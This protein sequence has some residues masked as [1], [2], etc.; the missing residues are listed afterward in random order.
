M[1]ENVS[2]GLVDELIS[3]PCPDGDANVAWTKICKNYENSTGATK[4]KM[5]GQFNDPTL[6]KL[7]KDPDSWISE[8]ELLRTRL[9]KIGTDIGDIYM[10]MHVLNNAPS[11]YDNVFENLED[12]LDVTTDPLTLETL[13][14]K[15]SEKN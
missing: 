8:L 2:F 4:V 3:L 12:K 14:E 5:I 10:M 6:N 11:A 1:T 13:R 15:L 9:K 7:S